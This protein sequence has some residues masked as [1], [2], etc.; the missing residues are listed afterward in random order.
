[1]DYGYVAIRALD[2]YQ[3]GAC[4]SRAL[5]RELVNAIDVACEECSGNSRDSLAGHIG[6]APARLIL[7]QLAHVL[8]VGH[9]DYPEHSS[10]DV[11]PEGD[12][13]ALEATRAEMHATAE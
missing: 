10:G 4:N 6:A 3:G 5:A 11:T 13:L 1:M 7:A 9:G 12:I 8:G 2:A